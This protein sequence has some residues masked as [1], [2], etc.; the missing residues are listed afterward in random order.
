MEVVLDDAE[1]GVIVRKV[2]LD[3]RRLKKTCSAVVVRR[4]LTVGDYWTGDKD[5]CCC[6]CCGGGRTCAA[7]KLSLFELALKR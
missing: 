2:E 4:S 7:C 3:V 5:C 1:T 6:C